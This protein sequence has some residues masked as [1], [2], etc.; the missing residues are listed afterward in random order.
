MVTF[1][2]LADSASFWRCF[3]PK[4]RRRPL[5]QHLGPNAGAQF[6]ATLHRML[7]MDGD[8]FQVPSGDP[9]SRD[10]L[11]VG[12]PQLPIQLSGQGQGKPLPST[13]CLFRLKY[14]FSC[15]HLSRTKHSSQNL[16]HLETSWVM[17][18]WQELFAPESL[19]NILWDQLTS[20]NQIWKKLHLGSR[21]LFQ[22]DVA[23]SCCCKND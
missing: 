16:K 14:S 1:N 6:L 9:Q 8:S 7:K 3:F 2:F 17:R 22:T 18:L 20:P 4:V 11:G 21:R 5:N 15:L 19:T 10:G 12:A 13:L 23:A